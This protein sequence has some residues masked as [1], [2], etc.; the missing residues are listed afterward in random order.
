MLNTHVNT[1]FFTEN[2]RVGIMVT[3]RVQIINYTNTIHYVNIIVV[4]IKL[5]ISK[6]GITCTQHIF[7]DK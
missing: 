5:N 6:I 3:S 2:Y 1:L 4:W 7:C